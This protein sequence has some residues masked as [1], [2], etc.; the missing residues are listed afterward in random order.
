MALTA[1][2][3]TFAEEYVRNGYNSMQAYRVA[4]PDA[5]D[6]TVRSSAYTVLKREEVK[7]YIRELQKEYFEAL[8]I[9]AER[10]A[11]ELAEMAFSNFDDNN[12]ATSKLKALDLLQKQMG[13][14]NQKMEINGEQKIVITIGEDEE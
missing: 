3:K 13:L 4:Y 1:K 10:I 12:T 8:N 7:A 5:S 11:C 2:Q 9:S 6:N 14:Q